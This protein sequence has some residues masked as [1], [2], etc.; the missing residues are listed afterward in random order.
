MI[1]GIISVKKS[2]KM[3]LFVLFLKFLPIPS[4]LRKYSVLQ[5]P[6]CR[7]CRDNYEEKIEFLLTENVCWETVEAYGVR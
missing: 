4:T 2:E 3:Y 1:K 6:K 5:R 7:I